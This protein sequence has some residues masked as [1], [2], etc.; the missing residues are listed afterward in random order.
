ML[1]FELDVLFMDKV[2]GEKHGDVNR[3]SLGYSLDILLSSEHIFFHLRK[4]VGCGRQVSAWNLRL[5][6]KG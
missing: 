6:V 4:G 5:G 1:L 2:S 3:L